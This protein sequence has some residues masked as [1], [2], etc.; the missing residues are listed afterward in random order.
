MVAV[1]WYAAAAGYSPGLQWCLRVCG[2]QIKNAKN[3]TQMDIEVEV[4]DYQSTKAQ[5]LDPNTKIYKIPT[6][7][8]KI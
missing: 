8:E 2:A 4:V 1:V 5:I 7:F 3:I 6:S